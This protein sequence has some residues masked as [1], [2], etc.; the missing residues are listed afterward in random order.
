MREVAAP[1]S[2]VRRD[3]ITGN[4]PFKGVAVAGGVSEA[5]SGATATQRQDERKVSESGPPVQQRQE[6]SDRRKGE[7]G[8]GEI[9][10]CKFVTD[11]PR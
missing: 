2:M 3:E 5:T 7:R 10:L 8:K 9:L 4:R 11:S 1:A 6:E